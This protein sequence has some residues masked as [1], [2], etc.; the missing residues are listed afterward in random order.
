[1]LGRLRPRDTSAAKTHGAAYSRVVARLRWGLPVAALIGLAALVLWPLW[2]AHK[3]SL[4]MVKN[5][6]NLMVEKL[7]LTGLDQNNQPYSLTADRALQAANAKNLVD[8]ENPKGEISLNNGTWIAG[9]AALGRLDQA[10]KKLWLGGGAEFFHDQGTRFASNE[11]N[12]DFGKNIAWG[13]QPV[14]IQGSFGTI[15]GGGFRVLE[16]GSTFIVTG[17]A[18]AKLRLQGGHPSGKPNINTSKAR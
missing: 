2:Q 12:V 6:P 17:P 7:N 4:V 11:M 14:V 16:G 1:M 10:A 5:I 15:E 9:H 18:R 3:V 13:G 8:L